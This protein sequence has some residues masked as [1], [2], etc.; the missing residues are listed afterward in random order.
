MHFFYLHIYLSMYLSIYLSYLS[1][2]L[3]LYIY[4][5]IYLVVGGEFGRGEERDHLDHQ[6]A[7]GQEPPPGHRLYHGGRHL[8]PCRRRLSLHPPQVSRG[9]FGQK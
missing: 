6:P 7:G 1:I 2:Y 5:S 3:S 8:L 4:L 9:I